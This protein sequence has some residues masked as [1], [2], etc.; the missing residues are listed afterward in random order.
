M[1][2]NRDG[3]NKTTVKTILVMAIALAGVDH[4]REDSSSVCVSV[5]RGGDKKRERVEWSLE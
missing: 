4:E 3:I 2:R 1:A 5:E